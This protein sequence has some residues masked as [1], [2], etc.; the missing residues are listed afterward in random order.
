MTFSGPL[1]N[2]PEIALNGARSL[3]FLLMWTLPTFGADRILILKIY[4]LDVLLDSK[5]PDFQVPRFPGTQKSG[6]GQ[7]WA[8][9]GLGCAGLG[10]GL[11][12]GPGMMRSKIH[13]I[14]PAN[15]KL[16]LGSSEDC[17]HPFKMGS[18]QIKP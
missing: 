3:V 13:E 7:A 9:P 4:I 6:L 15:K 11:G 1:K 8:G 17:I 12:L 18:H 5:F 14:A 16:G 10:P 2:W